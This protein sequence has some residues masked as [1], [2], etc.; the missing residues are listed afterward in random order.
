MLS[1]SI[2]GMQVIREMGLPGR[3]DQ[4]VK[5]SEA[6][7]AKI[8]DFQLDEV[9]QS[10]CTNPDIIPYVKSFCGQNA[11][12]VHT[13]FINKPPGAGINSRHP[14]HQDLAYFPFG[15]TNSIVA[16][17]AAL[18]DSNS[19]NGSLN[20]IVKTHKGPFYEHEYP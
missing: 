4:S 11:K 3:R 20:I 12:S 5:Q 19:T 1:F 18:E 7:I 14:F 17:W 16:A 2:P 8:Q 9:L 10:Y 15:P 13:M 6:N